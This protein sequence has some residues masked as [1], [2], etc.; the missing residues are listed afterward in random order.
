MKASPFRRPLAS[1]AAMIALC[2]VSCASPDISGRN[3]V[4]EDAVNQ[5]VGVLEFSWGPQLRLKGNA[6]AYLKKAD[7]AG[8][9]IVKEIPQSFWDS[10]A[11]STFMEG[12]PPF[13]VTA[14]DKLKRI[15][16]DPKVEDYANM[17][18]G[19][20][21]PYRVR[22]G[23]SNITKVL[24]DEEYKGSLATPGEKHRLILGTFQNT[25]TPAAAVVGRDLS[26]QDGYVGRF[27]C[28]VK[29]SDFKKEWSVTAL[30]VGSID[31]EQWYTSNV[32]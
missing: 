26:R 23:D 1:V 17:A 16:V 12:G 21:F 7:A 25:P 5:A 31:P 6:L 22:V 27:R 19:G 29:Y 8:L 24:T 30:D 18:G 3:R 15:A 2:A 13:A 10:F 4:I 14:T 20:I 9:V 11:S 32:K 28:V